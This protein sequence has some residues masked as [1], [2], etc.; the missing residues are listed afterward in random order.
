MYHPRHTDCRQIESHNLQ[1]K[2]LSRLNNRCR[3]SCC[4][5]PGFHHFPR[6]SLLY[7]RHWLR[8]HCLHFL[9]HH[10]CFHHFR[11]NFHL[12]CRRLLL[13]LH[14]YL[15]YHLLHYLRPLHIHHLHFH[16]HHTQPQLQLPPALPPQ[17]LLLQLL[18]ALPQS[19]QLLSPPESVQS[20][21]VAVQSGL[22]VFNGSFDFFL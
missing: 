3:K 22:H 21:P 7:S 4:F 18:P 9:R 5:L 12:R 13:L 10:H 11:R 6:R 8:C 16:L 19:L 14:L 17:P 20:L 1:L 15:Q 2:N